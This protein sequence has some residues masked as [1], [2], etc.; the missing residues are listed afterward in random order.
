M[1]G[2]R[3]SQAGMA[4]AAILVAAAASAAEPFALSPAELKS[5]RLPPGMKIERVAAAPLIQYPLF[6]CF[7]DAGRLYVAEGTGTN[8]PGTELVKRNLGKITRLEDTDGD[9]K[10]DKSIT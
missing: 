6:A 10:F 5:F 9:G 8:L 1:F 4:V 7:D 2:A 3:F